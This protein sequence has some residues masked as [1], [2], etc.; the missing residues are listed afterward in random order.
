M[1]QEF[2]FIYYRKIIIKKTI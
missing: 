2:K 1:T